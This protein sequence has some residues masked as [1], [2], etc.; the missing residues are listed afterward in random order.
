ML[1]LRGLTY[2]ALMSRRLA[3]GLGAVAVQRGA[4]ADHAHGVLQVQRPGDDVRHGQVLSHKHINHSLLQ[5]NKYKN[6][7]I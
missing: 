5:L 4:E 6:K 1:K 3:G 7:Q 2:Q